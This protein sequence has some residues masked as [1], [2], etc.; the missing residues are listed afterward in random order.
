MHTAHDRF[1]ELLRENGVEVIYYVDETAKALKD[2]AVKAEFLN[3]ML[4]ESNL[5]SEG[6]REAIYDYLINMQ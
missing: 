1:A 2:P 3:K 6:I 5:N 4:D